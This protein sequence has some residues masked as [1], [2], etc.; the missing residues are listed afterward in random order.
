MNASRRWLHLCLGLVAAAL[1]GC[2]P[3]PATT[4]T[5]AVER[6][7]ERVTAAEQ[8]LIAARA[9][10]DVALPWPLQP[11]AKLELWR[12]DLLDLDR[13]ELA[14][15]LEAWR[16]RPGL[17]ARRMKTVAKGGRLRLAGHGAY[18]VR[19]HLAGEARVG[20]ALASQLGLALVLNDSDFEVYCADADTGQPVQ[21]AFVKV[22]YRTER[23]GRDRVLCASGTTDAMGRWHSSLVRDRFAPLVVATA[24]ASHNNHYALTTARQLLDHADADYRLSIRARSA[25]FRQGERAE[26]TGVLQRRVGNR[27]APVGNAPIAMQ[28]LDP[29]G[30]PAA[31][32]NV[33]TSAVGAFTD[34]FAVSPTAPPGAYTVV[35]TVDGW[36]R[37]LDLFSVAP[38]RRPAFRLDVSLDHEVLAPGDALTLTLRARTADNKP[39]ANTRVRV[40]SW[41]YPVSL[42]R[43]APWVHGAEPID[44]ARVAVLPVGFPA[45]TRTDAKG[46]L[47]LK[48]QPTRAD[49]SRGDLLCAVRAQVVAN[50]L[51]SVERTREF[52]LL[53]QP[54]AVRVGVAAGATVSGRESF[55]GPGE[56]FELAF[57]SPLPPPEQKDAQAVC[58]LIY[59]D[60]NGAH[61]RFEL[62]RAP[63]AA[64]VKRRLAVAASQ[65]GRYAFRVEALGTV[66]EAVVWVVEADRNVPWGAAAE[67]ML[68][69][70]AP[71]CRRGEA[72]RAV[73]AAP[74]RAAPVALALRSG[75]VVQRQDVSLRTG[76]RSIRLRTTARH[77]DPLSATLVQMHKGKV[78]VGHATLGI[79]PGG[80]T[81]DVGV[82]LLWVRQGEWSGRGFGVTSK[83]RLGA[84]VQ[85]IVHTELVRPSFHG[86]PPSAIRRHTVQWHGGSATNSK[87]ELEVGLHESLLTKSYALFIQA[88]APDGRSGTTLLP[89]HRVRSAPARAPGQP[90]SPG[91]KLDALALHGLDTPTARWLA[92]R[93]LAQHSELATALPALARQAAT[94]HD[95]LAILALA[96]N[97]PSAVATLEAT[98]ARDSADRTAALAAASSFA[99]DARQLLE[100]LLAVDA[101]PK[102]R[103]AAAR[104]LRH[105]LPLSFAPLARALRADTSAQV[106]A[107]VAVALG[108][109]GDTAAR[110]LAEALATE[111]QPKVRVAIA[112]GLRQ[113]GGV[114]AADALLNLAMDKDADVAL[115][116]VRALPDIGYRGTDPRLLR[117]LRT[118]SPTLRGEVARVLAQSGAASATQAILD[119]AERR[120]T[121]ELVD[122]LA[123]LR[124]PRVQAAMLRWLAHDDPAVRV[125]AAQYLA[126]R[127]DERALPVLRTLLTPATPAEVTDRAATT[128]I[129]RRNDAAV[130]RLVKLLD[131]GRLSPAT[132]RALVQ[133]AG[134]LGWQQ[135]GR[136]LVAILARGL[137]EP[138]RLDAAD[139][140]QLWLD[141]L[142]AAASVGPIWDAVVER[143][144]PAPA[145]DALYAPA[146]RALRTDGLAAMLRALW[147]SPLPDDL[148]R[149]TVG[150]YARAQGPGAVPELM[151][152]LASPLL[153]GRAAKALADLEATDAL[154]AALRSRTPRTRGAAAA[155]LGVIGDA[156]A[157]PALEALVRDADAFVR[158]EAAHALATLTRRPT[159]Y[160]DHLSEPRQ[161]TP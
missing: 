36:P 45:D 123:L 62:C 48:W 147:R 17:L 95:A 85:S 120:P 135:A 130:P 33:R 137:A 156:R 114:V 126:A 89:T 80:R 69:A 15:W 151:P 83:D 49:L 144:T 66:S 116:A 74:T 70:E 63:V 113:A 99:A 110:A 42:D 143:S 81:L 71:W 10:G 127:G 149:A 2:P 104:L 11:G 40:L 87:G 103:A 8:P 34:A 29:S 139:Q 37:R 9:P 158:M 65:P 76:A 92:A 159:V 90:R 98:L 134:K 4:P 64:L 12:V 72:L 47:S 54:P 60:S 118:G 117:L 13:P 152:L 77:T 155:A 31:D 61:R 100:R 16:P 160:T 138:S 91:D 105:T 43:A 1:A 145:A 21:G 107:A 136:G 125:A 67:P 5:V 82:R 58:H 52:V 20:L 28:L 27:F 78:H 131:A 112:H 157:I 153:Q 57:D 41:G 115:A 132:Q 56:R 106:R 19:S 140:R 23:L 73:V 142:D 6:P 3:P 119:V 84:H 101:A 154:L 53:A 102:M 68:V 128:L 141:A 94:N 22:V 133:A 108:S 122:A 39:M 88:V 150:A 32:L 79:E 96:A 59:E 35:A 51:G 146:L 14:D 129:A 7:P 109:G 148:R 97:H 26:F 86:S 24:V 18:I 38:R 30:G 25:T 124:S 75:D 161:A 46:N 50:G 121:G 111:L 55:H 93:A 44:G